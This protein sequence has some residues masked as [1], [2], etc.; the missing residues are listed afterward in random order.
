M[1]QMLNMI[2]LIVLKVHQYSFKTLQKQQ[3]TAVSE[4]IAIIRR[5]V[6]K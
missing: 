4:N 5:L 3:I 6:S 2:I 1:E